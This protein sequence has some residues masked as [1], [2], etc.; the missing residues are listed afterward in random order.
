MLE[1]N[2]LCKIISLIFF[3]KFPV[4]SL[5]GKMNIQIP[6]FPCAVAT[7]NLTE[8]R[9]YSDSSLPKS[10][11]LFRGF[12]LTGEDNNGTC[13][14]ELKKIHRSTAVETMSKIQLVIRKVRPKELLRKK[15]TCVSTTYFLRRLHSAQKVKI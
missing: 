15:C 3:G 4:F 9:K 6:C 12:L 5:S 11:E 13:L 2:S 8:I 7:L 1:A 10:D 14:Y